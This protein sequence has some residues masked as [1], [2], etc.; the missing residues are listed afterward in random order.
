MIYNILIPK[1]SSR[2]G[3]WLV[4]FMAKHDC[5]IHDLARHCNVTKHSIET[6]LKKPQNM[7]IARLL[8]ISQFI[9]KIDPS[10]ESSFMMMSIQII[11]NPSIKIPPNWR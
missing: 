3:E 11:T 7:Q 4:T 8:Q 1:D 2:W 10:Y 5:T 6:W 9:A